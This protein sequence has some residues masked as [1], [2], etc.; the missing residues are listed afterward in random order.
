MNQ[1][2]K[3]DL[4]GKKNYILLS[5]GAI[6]I[7]IGYIMM[8]GKGST[9]TAYNPDIFSN[10]RIGVA[11]VICLIGY[12]MNIVGILISPKSGNCEKSQ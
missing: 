2:F 5:V 12:L 6:L 9:L 7:L 1:K 8:S 3:N 10:L 11:P 4:F